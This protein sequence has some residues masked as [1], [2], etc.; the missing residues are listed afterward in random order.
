MA[1]RYARDN[2]GRFASTG[3]GATARGGR[4]RTASGNKRA[5]QTMRAA[6]AGGVIKG[7]TARTVAG[8]KVMAKL[9]KPKVRRSQEAQA[10]RALARV[11][12]RA[13]ALNN[14]AYTP[15][16]GQSGLINRKAETALLS[17]LLGAKTNRASAN[18]HRN[19]SASRDRNN[20]KAKRSVDVALAANEVYRYAYSGGVATGRRETKVSGLKVRAR[21]R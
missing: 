2:R 14:Q 8:Q 18:Y 6:G 4:L 3:S 15:K 10:I 9:A 5:T 21:K 16:S 12:T 17:T 1:R 11:Q 20:S 7:R 13:K 19:V